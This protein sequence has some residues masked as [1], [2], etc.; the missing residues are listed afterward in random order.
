MEFGLSSSCLRIIGRC[1][2]TAA[3]LGSEATLANRHIISE[4]TSYVPD[5]CRHATRVKIDPTLALLLISL[6]VISTL[7]SCVAVLSYSERH[8]L[9]FRQGG[10]NLITYRDENY[11]CSMA[12]NT[13]VSKPPTV[14]TGT[15]RLRPSS[16]LSTLEKA[17]NRQAPVDSE[18]GSNTHT[19]EQP[20]PAGSTVHALGHKIP[21]TG[22][23]QTPAQTHTRGSA[24]TSQPSRGSLENHRPST[25]GGPSSKHGGAVIPSGQGTMPQYKDQ[26]MG[27]LLNHSSVQ[28]QPNKNGS[29]GVQ[30]GVGHQYGMHG[31]PYGVDIAGDTDRMGLNRKQRIA[32][33]NSPLHSPVPSRSNSRSPVASP[34][35]TVSSNGGNMKGPRDIDYTVRG[36]D[37]NAGDLYAIC[38]AVPYLL[39][40]KNMV[41]ALTT[42]RSAK[43]PDGVFIDDKG[44]AILDPQKLSFMD[45][46]LIF[47]LFLLRTP[48][49]KHNDPIRQF[50]THFDHN[51]DQLIVYKDMG[52]KKPVVCINVTML[53]FAG[54][55]LEWERVGNP[56]NVSPDRPDVKTPWE[57][58]LPLLKAR[59]IVPKHLTKALYENWIMMPEDAIPDKLTEF[60]GCGEYEKLIQQ[61]TSRNKSRRTVARVG[62]YGNTIHYTL[63]SPTDPLEPG[64]KRFSHQ[65]PSGK[66]VEFEHSGRRSTSE[67]APEGPLAPSS[68]EATMSGALEKKEEEVKAVEEEVRIEPKQRKTGWRAKAWWW[69]ILKFVLIVLLVAGVVAAVVCIVYFRVLVPDGEGG[70]KNTYD[71]AGQ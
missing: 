49:E 35:G 68:D 52:T 57:K 39:G 17:M 34:S 20:L 13:A 9:H 61:Y 12:N 21:A 6:L 18:H 11:P 47:V 30:Q 58:I 48:L 50:L 26:S 41:D 64:A 70:M 29:L 59:N 65:H 19:G 44:K 71:T 1:T 54:M 69:R 33:R 14:L 38:R 56:G 31:N 66:L 32:R 16:S 55:A 27:A 53:D 15:G 45:K 62:F 67:R 4:L 5:Q 40:P 22:N 24:R 2:G 10:V 42:M 60:V 46:A 43:I 28:N 8:T 37:E 63:P 23:I 7:V 51:K 25:F 3:S 36:F